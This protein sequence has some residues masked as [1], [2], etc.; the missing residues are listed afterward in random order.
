MTGD[1]QV[2]RLRA[3]VRSSSWLMTVLRAARACALPDWHVGAGVLRDLVWD[4]MHGGF[5]PARVKDVDVGFFDPDDL[6]PLRDE[7]AESALRSRLPDV[8]WEAKNQAAVH[9]WYER[10]FG[11]PAEP[12]TSSA[13]AV[14]TF[15]ETATAL[16]VR[17][18]QDDRLDV[19]APYGLDDLFDGVWRLN[20][21]RVTVEEYRRRIARK[22]PRGRW[23]KVRVVDA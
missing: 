18:Q 20:P 1:P 3:V 13:E 23:P 14:A 17:L 11:V 12:L 22:Q 21:R 10:K 15:P 5:D 8:P 19:I 9:L 6:S 16:A 7:A 4:E 2:E